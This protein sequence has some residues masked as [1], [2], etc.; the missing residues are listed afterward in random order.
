MDRHVIGDAAELTPARLT[1]IL[2]RH[3]CLSS[4]EVTAVTKLGGVAPGLLASVARLGI[5]YSPA[6]RGDLPASLFLKL[7][8]ADLHPELA[9]AGRHEMAFYA[10]LAG[11]TA[12]PTPTIYDAQI[13]DA[14]GSHI[15][16]QDL[17]PTHIQQP[18]PIPPSMAHSEA[19]ATA[20]A[21]LHA[22]RWGDPR[23]GSPYTWEEAAATRKRLETSFPKFCDYLGDA[24]LP[25]QKALYERLIGS[26]LLET[27]SRR[28]IER[29]RVSL[30]HGDAHA[31]NMML[32]RAAGGG[33]M[34]IDWQRWAIDVPMLDLA[35][36]IAPHWPA[37]LRAVRERPLVARYHQTLLAGG[38]TGY[39]WQQCWDDY[40]RE[41]MICM[42]IPIGQHRRGGPA[43]MVWF[44]MQSA[45][46][47]VVDLDCLE[48]I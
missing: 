17:A 7:T 40:R 1:E 30:V 19:I 21:H 20:L 43:G 29:D 45:S 48:L 11:S 27:L 3:G 36:L 42:L 4:G 41:V 2:H 39:D 16:M 31:G 14:G 18:L 9:A 12:S 13:D 37:P 33:V 47:A 8:R 32:P 28:I 6:A 44:G 46:E 24:L 10:A 35:F 25:A 15:L 5:D 38:V 34:L 26:N 23:L 22:E